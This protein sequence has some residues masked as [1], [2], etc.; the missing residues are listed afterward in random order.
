MDP[1][2]VDADGHVLEPMSAW[3]ELPEQ[4]QLRVTRDQLGLDHVLV[5]DQEIVTVS[6]GL[7][8]TPGSRMS[9]F[10]NSPRYEEAQPGGF[11]PTARLADMDVEGIDAAVLYPSVGLNFWALEDVTAAVALA[12]AYNDWLAAYCAAAPR[13]L[14]G[15]A[16]LPLQDPDACV[17]ELRRACTEL[18]FPA[19][20]VRPN[21]CLGRAISDPAHESVWAAAEELGVTVGVHEGSSN[22]IR[23]LGMDRPFNP[24]ILHAVSHAFEQMLAC[25]QLIAFGVMERHPGLR[26]VFLEAGG[27]WAPYWLE[28][29]D[30]QVRGFGG[31]CPEMRLLPSEYF[32]RQ[33]WVSFEVDE[34]TL[35][36]LVP[37][38]GEDRIVWGSDYPH[39]DAT[40]PGAVKELRQVIA[41]LRDT[42]QAKILGANA[43]DLYRLPS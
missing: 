15:A 34:P 29:L 17:R 32:A 2:V 23:T 39:H 8:G 36:A 28:R 10:A 9:D 18:G 12:G 40:F 33:C 13:R 26:F 25:A 42:A 1:K 38:V 11:D 41:P 22:T 20:F 31:Y 30:E 7:L 21:P 5:G 37:F 27:G 4:Y 3:A 19:A 24:L 35:P 14:F 6:L 16:M 43:A